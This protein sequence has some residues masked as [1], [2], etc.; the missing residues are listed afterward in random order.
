MRHDQQCDGDD[1]VAEINCGLYS[2]LH[3]SLGAIGQGDVCV[4]G[5]PSYIIA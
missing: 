2:V 4:E 5:N 3:F 1:L